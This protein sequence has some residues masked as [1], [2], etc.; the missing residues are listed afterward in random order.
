MAWNAAL[1]ASNG[2]LINAPGQLQANFAAIALGTDTSLLITNAKCAAAMGL[3]DSKLAQITTA[4]KVSGTALCNLGSVP[5]GAGTL[6][7]ANIPTTLTGK[8]AD[9]LDGQEGTYYRDVDNANAGDLAVVRGGLGVSFA[10]TTVGY[11]LYFS[12]TGVISALPPDNGKYLKSNGAAAPS[13][14]AVTAPIYTT[15][16]GSWA[17]ATEGSSTQAVTDGFI[18]VVR[19]AGGTSAWTVKTDSANPPTKIRSVVPSASTA[20]HSTTT[21]VKK[22]EYYLIEATTGNTGNFTSYWIPLS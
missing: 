10:A 5:S 22:G 9:T 17:A 21:P 7:L 20:T 8:D 2:L 1:P 6:P 18:C 14:A 3:V 16:F 13:W 19:N 4:S 12:A 15:G 11:I